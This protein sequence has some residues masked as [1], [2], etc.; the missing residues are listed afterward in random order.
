MEPSYFYSFVLPLG[1]LIGILACMVF[2][3]ARKE[4]KFEKAFQKLMNKYMENIREQ[5]KIFAEEMEKLDVLLR[6]NSIDRNTYERLKKILEIN[7]EKRFEE[8][9][10]QFKANV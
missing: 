10:S 9:R 7:L 4:E 1:V 2:L 8:V 3:I 5:E 6:D